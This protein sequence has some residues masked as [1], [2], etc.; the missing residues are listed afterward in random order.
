MS[1]GFLID[2]DDEEEAIAEPRPSDKSVLESIAGIKLPRGEGICTRVPLITRLQNHRETEVYLEYNGNL[3]PTDEAHIADVIILATNEIARHGKG[4][5]DISS[6]LIVKKNGVPDLTMVDLPRI[7]RVTVLGQ[8]EDMLE[9]I[10]DAV[11]IWI[12]C[13]SLNVSAEDNTTGQK[14]KITITNDKGR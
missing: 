8:I 4:I 11:V 7:T 2:V 1:L 3:V 10:S 13:G 12:I 9:Q 14:N 6:K 5:S